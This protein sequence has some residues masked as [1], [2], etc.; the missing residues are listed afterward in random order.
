MSHAFDLEQTKRRAGEAAKRNDMIVAERL[1]LDIAQQ[2]P[3][4]VDALFSLGFHAQMKGEV[5]LAV[6][7]F[8][9]AIEY[10]PSNPLLR[11]TIAK[12]LKVNGDL[13]G[14]FV[15]LVAAL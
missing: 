9:A 13:E 1:W 14:H 11:T 8:R 7:R 2:F 15:A 5:K 12:A 10:S 4:D 6:Q 3:Q